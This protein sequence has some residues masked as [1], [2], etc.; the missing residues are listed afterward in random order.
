MGAAGREGKDDTFTSSYICLCLCFIAVHP[1]TIL[2]STAATGLV[3]DQE[4]G[5]LAQGTEGE[6]A[7]VTMRDAAP[8]TESV[9]GGSEPPAMTS[10]P[11][12]VSTSFFF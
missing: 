2:L 6:E 12:P 4:K 5:A 1:H 8:E 3:L 7:A 10:C 9:Q 11:L